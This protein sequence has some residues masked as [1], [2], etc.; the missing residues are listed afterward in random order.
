[1]MTESICRHRIICA[2]SH[3]LVCVYARTL[4]C[5]DPVYCLSTRHCN[6][7]LSRSAF[8]GAATS[9]LMHASTTHLCASPTCNTKIRGGDARSKDAFEPLARLA[10][11]LD[12]RLSSTSF[13]VWRIAIA[14]Y[15]P[16]IY[17]LRLSR[18]I[19]SFEDLAN[20]KVGRVRAFVHGQAQ[21][22]E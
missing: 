11:S 1:M 6:F 20:S 7:D 16:S 12:R 3:N 8:P 17:V 5:G 14:L 9:K 22:V 10:Q 2:V 19:C 21:V 15:R 13:R 18:C 4:V